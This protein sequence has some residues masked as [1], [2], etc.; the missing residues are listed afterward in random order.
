MSQDFGNSF[1]LPE[2]MSESDLEELM[3]KEINSIGLKFHDIDMTFN[4]PVKLIGENG[5]PYTMYRSAW[6]A[7]L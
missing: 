3:L 7:A 6:R 1:E 2:K 4:N 5:K